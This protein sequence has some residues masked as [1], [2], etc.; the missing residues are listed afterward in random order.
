MKTR[1]EFGIHIGFYPVPTMMAV[2]YDY[3]T[4]NGGRKQTADWLL[5]YAPSRDEAGIRRVL[6]SEFI[7][8]MI[9][10][11]LCAEAEEREFFK[12]CRKQ[13]DGAA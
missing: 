9:P 5:G 4:G 2:Y 6:A 8:D 1:A 7:P 12:N 3:L 11:F 13:V 10:D